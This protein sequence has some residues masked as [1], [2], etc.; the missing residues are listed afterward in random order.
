MTE[1]VPLNSD[2]AAKR[3]ATVSQGVVLGGAAVSAS[4]VTVL[5]VKTHGLAGQEA[6]SKVRKEEGALAISIKD[7]FAGASRAD[8]CRWSLG[9]GDDVRA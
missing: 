4:S 3:L 5:A 9:G 8:L 7:A 6:S 2:E 1:A